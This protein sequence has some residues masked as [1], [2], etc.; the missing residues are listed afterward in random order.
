MKS[1]TSILA[2]LLISS[3]C[4]AL[5]FKTDKIKQQ[6]K[7]LEKHNRSLSL[8]VKAIDKRFKKD[9]KKDVVLTEVFR[10][11]EEQDKIYGKNASISPHMVWEAVD[12]RTHGISDKDIRSLLFALNNTFNEINIYPV[13]A[14]F[15]DIGLGPHLHIQFR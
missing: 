15:H 6:F 8:I 9:L 10:T 13:T 3:P 1:L 4:L 7:E 12:I 14:I 11:F 2:V 5:E